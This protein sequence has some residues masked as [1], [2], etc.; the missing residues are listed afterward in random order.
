MAKTVKQVP[1]KKNKFLF[2]SAEQFRVWD[3]SPKTFG[4]HFTGATLL[5][6]MQR[7]KEPGRQTPQHQWFLALQGIIEGDRELK[8]AECWLVLVDQALVAPL[9]PKWIGINSEERGCAPIA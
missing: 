4:I 3:H 7:K 5:G 2:G 1:W 8:N 6:T 9:Q